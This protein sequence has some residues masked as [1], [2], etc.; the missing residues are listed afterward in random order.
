MEKTLGSLLKYIG[1]L[2]V[3]IVILGLAENLLG[4]GSEYVNKSIAGHIAGA[5]ALNGADTIMTGIWTVL[6]APAAGIL[7]V[8]WHGAAKRNFRLVFMCLIIIAMLCVVMI[9]GE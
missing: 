8:L 1:L 9:A 2:G 4:L 6:A 5:F 7:Y 3:G